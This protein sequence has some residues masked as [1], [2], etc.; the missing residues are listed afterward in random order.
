M[1]Q[2]PLVP[3]AICQTCA[4]AYELFT[5]G[6]CGLRFL[7]GNFDLRDLKPANFKRS[8]GITDKLGVKKAVFDMHAC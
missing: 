1:G 6:N 3:D 8:G 4:G 7:T 2:V 5:R